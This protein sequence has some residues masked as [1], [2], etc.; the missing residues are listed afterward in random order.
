MANLVI[1]AEERQVIGKQVK[2]LRREGKLPAVIYGKYVEQPVPIMMNY[3]DA[4]QV[5]NQVAQS[6]LIDIDVDG[7]IYPV[8][9]RQKQRN[10]I[11]GNLIHVDFMAVSL[12]EKL[13]AHVRVEVIGDSPAVKD[14]SALIVTGLNEL[15]VECL[16]ADLPNKIVVDISNLRR[17]GEAIYVRD[18]KLADNILV[19]D[20]PDTIIVLI[21]GQAAEEEVEAP[22]IIAEPEIIEHG[23]KEEEF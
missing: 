13:R 1:H 23:K 21:T 9:I 6:T 14:Y 2:A 15:E 7:H 22:A 17:V 16:P 12:Q 8:L 11:K 3:R 20:D 10:F 4:S 19:L 5:L 18:L